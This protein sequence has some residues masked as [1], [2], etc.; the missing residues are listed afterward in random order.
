[1]TD[2]ILIILHLEFCPYNPNKVEVVADNWECEC[3]EQDSLRCQSGESCVK[4]EGATKAHCSVPCL[5]P[6]WKG[7]SDTAVLATL[8]S[9]DHKYLLGENTF[10][11]AEH[12]YVM[13]SKVV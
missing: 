1:M 13:D 8:Q 10:H 6:A 3:D 7:S 5:N 9:S 4:A 2:Y 11:C 12:H